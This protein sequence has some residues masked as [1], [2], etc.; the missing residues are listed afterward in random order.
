MHDGWRANASFDFRQKKKQPFVF[1]GFPI[2]KKESR[3]L[4]YDVT[5]V[6]VHK[7]KVGKE[8]TKKRNIHAVLEICSKQAKQLI[9]DKQNKSIGQ[10]RS[11][12]Q[13]IIKMLCFLCCGGLRTR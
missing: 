8:V 1:F 7:K 10:E 13:E 4:T 6:K 3:K 5:S 9:V 11:F 2:C 12:T